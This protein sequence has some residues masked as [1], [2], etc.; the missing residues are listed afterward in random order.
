MKLISIVFSFKNEE[1]NIPELIERVVKVFSSL[2][3]WSYELVFVNDNSTDKSEEILLKFQKKVIQNR[4]K[5]KQ[6]KNR[7]RNKLKHKFKLIIR[8]EFK[9]ANKLNTGSTTDSQTDRDRKH[10]DPAASSHRAG[11]V[12]LLP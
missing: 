9:R 7:Y 4:L 10:G 6:F 1:K 12:S 2:P 5:L 3:N 8:V 11:T